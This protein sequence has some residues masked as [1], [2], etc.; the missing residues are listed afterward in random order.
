V[1]HSLGERL[2]LSASVT[3]HFDAAGAKGG[4][5]GARMQGVGSHPEALDGFMGGIEGD[6][7]RALTK[8]N[9]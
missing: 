2:E 9:R 6:I 7:T 8:K 1:A 5:R 4:G 3:R